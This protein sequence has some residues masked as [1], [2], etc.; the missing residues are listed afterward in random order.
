MNEEQTTTLRLPCSAVHCLLGAFFM[1]DQNAPYYRANLR[2]LVGAEPTE[3][4]STPAP[5]GEVGRRWGGSGR[6]EGNRLGPY[7]VSSAPPGSADC[8]YELECF[9]ETLRRIQL[10]ALN[11]TDAG[12]SRIRHSQAM[13][14]IVNVPFS[15][16]D[17]ATSI[18]ALT[19][20]LEKV[21]D[22]WWENEIRVVTG[23]RHTEMQWL[24]DLL[25]NQ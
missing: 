10:N 11:A 4:E 21:P 1:L 6:G 19:I 2:R 8:D 14:S 15:R 22:P 5:E 3:A 13:L 17:L 16:R 25:I 20:L 12:K 24:H 23:H 18:K 7:G 9:R